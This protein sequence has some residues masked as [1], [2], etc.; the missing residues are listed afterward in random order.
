MADIKVMAAQVMRGRKPL[1]GPL[2]AY[3]FFTYPWP[4]SWSPKKR[5]ATYWKT[6][7]CDLSNLQKLVEDALIGIAFS[8]DALIVHAV[9][10]KRYGDRAH[11]SIRVYPLEAA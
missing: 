3:M 11:T 4:A 2:S 7:R 6:S 8:D 10:E 9:T 5:A 1:E